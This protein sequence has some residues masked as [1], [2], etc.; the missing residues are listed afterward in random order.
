MGCKGLKS[1][2]SVRN[3]LIFFD[4]IVQQIEVRVKFVM[5]F[6]LYNYYCVCVCVCVGYLISIII[7]VW[8]NRKRKRE[9]I[10]VYVVKY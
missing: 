7:I 5:E 4:L 2:I 10:E 6:D 1:I 9:N 8:E 3:D